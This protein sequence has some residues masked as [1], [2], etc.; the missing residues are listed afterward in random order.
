MKTTLFGKKL[1]E[2][3]QISKSMPPFRRP[4]L[5]SHCVS[6]TFSWGLLWARVAS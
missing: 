4:R 3:C 5:R 1:I 6:F 2:K